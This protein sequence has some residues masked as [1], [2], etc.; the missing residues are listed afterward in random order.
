MSRP[1]AGADALV[2]LD[3]VFAQMAM[4]AGHNLWSLPDL[5]PREKTFVCL[6]ADLCHPHLGTPLAMHIEM[7][8]THDVDAESIRELFRHLAPYVG[9]PIVVTA[10]QRLTELG[11]PAVR[12]DQPPTP[13]P[14][15]DTLNDIVRELR[16]IAPGLA[17]FTEAQLTQ[18]WTRPHLSVRERALACLVVD[19]FYQTLG[20]SLQLHSRIARAAG[21]TDQTL[22]NLLRATAEFGLPRTWAA[23]HALAASSSPTEPSHP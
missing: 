7:A 3:P 19:I 22:D 12:D 20:P 14:L 9:Y 8:S 17:A 1:L 16:T 21:A 18:R 10:F 6:T 13:A 4:S 15:D 23:A 11:L 5:T 2:Q